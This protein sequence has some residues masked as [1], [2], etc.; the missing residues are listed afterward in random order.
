MHFTRLSQLCHVD[1]FVLTENL[2]LNCLGD[3][4]FGIS[5]VLQKGCY[6]LSYYSNLHI[7]APLR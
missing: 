6:K 4:Y 2:E 3:R 5:V 7:W 1:V